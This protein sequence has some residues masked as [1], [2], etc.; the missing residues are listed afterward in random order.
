[1]GHV[2]NFLDSIKSRRP[3]VAPAH[4]GHRSITPGHLGFV[5]HAVGRSLSWDAVAEQIVGDPEAQRLL[6]RNPYRAPWQA[7]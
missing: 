7:P 6:E 4:V 5:S 3:C 2:R 1:M